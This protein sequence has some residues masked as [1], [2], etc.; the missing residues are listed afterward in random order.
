[1]LGEAGDSR[2]GAARIGWIGAA[3][4]T[5]LWLYG[6]L[7]VGHPAL[8]DWQAYVPWWIADL[9]PNLESEIG[10]ALLNAAMIPIT[11]ASRL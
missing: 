9:L 10:M 7:A 2:A 11:W 3:A 4:G 1:M 6:Y 8:I 5:A